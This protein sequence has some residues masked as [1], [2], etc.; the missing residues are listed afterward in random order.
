MSIEL[1]TDLDR[2]IAAMQAQFA[3]D[4]TFITREV[5]SPAGLRCAVFFFDGMV[6]ALAINQS[7]IRPLMNAKAPRLSADTLAQSV[8]EINDSRVEPDLD[9]MLASFLYGDTVILTEGDARPVV[10]NTKGFS[11]RSTSEPEGEKVLRGPRE[12]FTE[13][14]MSNLS[15]LRRRLNDPRLKFT[16]SRVGSRTNTVVCLCYLEGV[17]DSALVDTVKHR[18]AKLKPDSVLDS[19]YIAERI[20]DNRRSPFPTLGATERPDVAAARL[21]EGRVAI[22]VDGSPVVLTAPCILQECFQSN[23]D[24]Y[25]SVEQAGLSRLLRYAAFLLTLTVPALYLAC[26]LHHQ[27]LV[28]TRLLLAIS[29]AQRGT[30]LP[31]VWEIFLLLIVFELLKEA[32]TRTPGVIGQTMSIVGGLVLGQAA[33]QARFISAPGVIIVAVAGVTGLALPKLQSATTVLR[34]ALT[35]ASALLGLYGLAFGLALILLHLCALD[36]CQ[37]PYLLN[38]VPRVRTHKE[39][40]YLRA[41]WFRMRRNRFLAQKEDK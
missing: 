24:Y 16:F 3:G 38:L 37:T 19:N 10:V 41:P 26:V 2:S 6:N 18:L 31:P 39:D 29:A 1:T 12:G 23:D 30:P 9:R 34:F 25:I 7:I 13:L 17:A 33:V 27:E 36:S 5:R 32:G 21:L 22:V 14:F 11:T 8:I 15:M 20:R 28:P 4:N 35:A 40:S